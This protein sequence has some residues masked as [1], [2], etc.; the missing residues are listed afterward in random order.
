[1][2]PV[3]GSFTTQALGWR[4]SLWPL[5]FS[6]GAAFVLSFVGLP[7]TSSSNILLRRAKRLRELTGNEKLKSEGELMSEEM[8]GS[9]IAAMTLYRPFKLMIVGKFDCG[10]QRKQDSEVRRLTLISPGPSFTS[11]EP[12]I[13]FLNL[14][15]ALVYAVLYCFFE[16]FPLVFQGRH[17][18]ALGVSGLPYI[19]IIIGTFLTYSGFA[20]WNHKYI[21]PKI[22][23]GTLTPEDRLY[24]VCVG[25]ICLP[26]CLFWVSSLL[27]TLSARD[28]FKSSH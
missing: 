9:E 25:A 5:L 24:P 28:L 8:T 19:A 17:G 2:G 7:E 20:Y 11:T 6:S 15:I 21:T 4:W 14:H 3:I 12:V 22:D 26:I 10:R 13:F 1:M 27:T 18:F 16:V 23:K